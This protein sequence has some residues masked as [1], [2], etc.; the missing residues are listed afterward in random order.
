MRKPDGRLTEASASNV[1]VVKRG[2]ILTPPKSNLILPG[3]TYDVV[4]ELAQANGLPLESRD[5]DEREVRAADELWVTSSSKEVL[6]IVSLDG[7]RV[8]D[9]RP[10]PVFARMY[11]LYQEFKQKVMRAGKREAVS[12]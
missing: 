1:F 5:V 11:Q 3:I 7:A 8:G 10:G 6:A 9:G 12:A 2:T 4:T